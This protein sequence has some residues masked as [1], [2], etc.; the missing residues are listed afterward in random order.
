MGWALIQHDWYPYKKGKLGHRQREEVVKTE[1]EDSYLQ[2]KERGLE[3]I[4]PRSLRRDLH[5][6]L[7]L[8]D[9]RVV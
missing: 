8:P 5:L 3:K 4:L 2:V 6:A 1:G 9:S 7:R